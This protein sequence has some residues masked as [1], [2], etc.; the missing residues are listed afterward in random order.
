[1]IFGFKGLNV[2]IPIIFPTKRK[3]F[4]NHGSGLFLKT[5]LIRLYTAL[6]LTGL[7]GRWRGL[8]CEVAEI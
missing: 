3:G 8:G 1:M 4:I 2:R 5:A 7:F 6:G